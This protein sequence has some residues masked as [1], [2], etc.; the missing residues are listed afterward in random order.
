MLDRK[1]LLLESSKTVRI[2]ARYKHA[3]L[4]EYGIGAGARVLTEQ[5]D[6]P[7]TTPC[8]NCGRPAELIFVVRER[9]DPM[10]TV[11]E[12]RHHL[13]HARKQRSRERRE[14]LLAP[15]LRVFRYL[16]VPQLRLHADGHNPLESGLMSTLARKVAARYVVAKGYL[17]VNDVVLYGR[18]KNHKGRIVSFGSDKYG[19]PIMEVE[20]IP[21]GR[22]QNK[23]MQRIP[24]L[25]SRRQRESSR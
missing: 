16:S 11:K 7:L 5:G 23:I 8:S 3:M 18:W 15:R 9:F 10:K 25:E 20:P 19:N 14:A 22:K 2:V 4:L 21:K 6:F 1:G 17:N 13:S 24:R 12:Q